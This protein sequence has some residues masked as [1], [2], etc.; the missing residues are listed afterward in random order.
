MV[1]LLV[2]GLRESTAIQRKCCVITT[3]MA[4]LVNSPLDAAHFLPALVPGGFRG[5][6]VSRGLQCEVQGARG[7]A[8]QQPAWCCGHA[9]A[10]PLVEGDGAGRLRRLAP[11]LDVQ[12]RRALSVRI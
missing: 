4:K 9:G 11:P 3:N 1:P 6:G 5:F 12:E 10:R 8:G 2:R 7:S